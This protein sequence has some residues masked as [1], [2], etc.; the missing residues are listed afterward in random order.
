MKIILTNCKQT[1]KQW[2]DS[3]KLN[4]SHKK[5][6]VVAKRTLRKQ[7]RKE[8]FLDR[9]TFYEDLMK[10]PSSEKFYQLIRRNRGG[11]ANLTGSILHDGEEVREPDKQRTVFAQYYEDLACPKDDSYDSSYLELCTV[12]HE[13]IKQICEASNNQLEPI[14]PDEV[15][16]AMSQLNSKKAA[17]EQGLTAEHLKYSGKVLIEEITD[18]FNSIIAEGK[19]PQMFKS[20]ILTPVLKKSKDPTLL[21]NYRRIT[22]T[23]VLGKLF[24]ITI[25]PRIA[26][27]FDQSTLQFGFT[28]GLSPVM[29]ALIVSEARA[30]VKMNSS[31][32]LFLVTLD[33]RKAFDVVHHTILMDKLYESNIHPS[34][35]TIV[36][37]LYTGMTTKVKWLGEL[38]QSFPINQGVRQGGILSPF[39][40]KTY[41][42]PCL[43]ELK[44]H[45]IG[46][47]I[48]NIYCGCP[49]Y[50]DDLAILSE[51]ENE[52]QLMGN[53]IGRH[54]RQD[55]VTIHPNKS[56]AVLLHSHKSVNK[57][58]FSLELNDKNI[59][60]TSSTTHLGILRSETCEN[61]INI[62]DRL[63]L[64]RR[65]LYTLINTGVHG[66]NGLNPE[67]S[68]KIYQ[69][70][71]V[72]RL[73]FGLEVLPI[74]ATQ[75]S[76]LSRFHISN[77]RRFQSLPERTA[78]SA[79]YLLLG[80]LPI[81]AELHKRQLSLLYNLIT[82]ENETIQ[83]LTERQIVVNLDNK[84]SYYCRVQEIL[85]QYNLPRLQD[86]HLKLETKEK[87]K[88]QVKKAVSEFWS[89]KLK[90]EAR[91]KSTLKYLNIDSLSIENTHFVWRTLESTVTDIRKGITKCRMLTGTYMLQSNRHKFSRTIVSPTCRICGLES[92][93][94]T[95]MLLNCSSLIDIRKQYYSNVKLKVI[96]HIGL[97]QW[98]AVF[99]TPEKI[100]QLI[101]DSSKFKD[102]F[103]DIAI[104]DIT[105][106]S[107][108]LCH[109]LHIER[110]NKS[111]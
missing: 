1:Y 29:A 24:E 55:R 30:E 66:A 79:V 69:C 78:T 18:I 43:I 81:E 109:R 89:E 88:L 46:L 76:I 40:Y 28:K 8:K 37:D 61:S 51:C 100:V 90:I 39:L 31:A 73:L 77:L 56:N 86:L 108:E 27:N 60:L 22:V 41:I 44:Q 93:D 62:D 23:P 104:R 57:K 47:S 59:P 103:S 65:T 32:P 49:T 48:G 84:Y 58:E 21:D 106:V 17:D 99:N 70:Y 52:L 95:H 5:A 105:K 35:W 12:R 75:M 9:K 15:Y 20:G 50:A 34:L 71:V 10:N 36:N 26:E 110:L 45:K 107:T 4:D 63:S 74:T 6:N 92:E 96:E 54:S 94:I 64:A 53:V 38:S 42:N 101:L 67:I 25:L 3:G 33:S 87:W 68:F 111:E 19:V 11:C 102:L 2:I 82:S 72:P 98:K 13:L 85:I 14:T 91:E 97:K 16:K 83:E 7:I 80:A